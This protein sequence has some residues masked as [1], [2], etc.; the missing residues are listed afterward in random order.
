MNYEK[1]AERA[2]KLLHQALP[3]L[4]MG[5]GLLFVPPVE[6][7]LR[8][9]VFE[10]SLAMKG[11]A[12]FWRVV[13]PLYRPPTHLI[14]NYADR[15]LG[16]ERVSLLEPEL[17][18]TINRLTQIISQGQI[19][20]LKGFRSPQDFLQKI[21]WSSRPSSPNYQVDL[22]LTQYMAGNVSACLEILE[23]IV[24]AKLSPRWADTVRLAQELVDELRM[25]PSALGR[26]IKVWEERNIEWF[27]LVPRS[28]RRAQ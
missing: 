17:D 6:H 22:A 28:R 27:H 24:C 12:Y 5:H 11:T 2:V 3:A 7:L 10:T 8:C 9:F 15:L 1:M 19:D 25:N 21:D 26:R 18:Q 16:G 13:I 23:Q 14:L 20:Y 4:H